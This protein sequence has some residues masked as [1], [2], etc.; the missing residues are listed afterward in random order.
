VLR[1]FAFL[2]VFLAHSF[3]GTGHLVKSFQEA[4][5][6]GL[7]LFF[8]LSSFL[9]TELLRRERAKTGTIDIKRFY[10]RRILRIW[11]LYLSFVIAVFFLWHGAQPPMEPISQGR[12]LSYMGLSANWYAVL[13]RNIGLSPISPLWSIS[14]EE[15]FYLLWP[16]MFLLGGKRLTTLLSLATLPVAMLSIYWVTRQANASDVQLWP[17]SFV[18]FIFFGLGALTALYSEHLPKLNS[19]LSRVALLLVSL[20]VSLAG[21]YLFNPA[22]PLSM[23]MS[24]GRYG[25][26]LAATAGIFLAFYG[27]TWAGSFSFPV[28]LGKISYGLYVFHMLSIEAAQIC[29]PILIRYVKH[30]GTVLQLALSLTFTI[31]LAS[32][33]YR[34]LETPFLRLKDK[35]TIIASRSV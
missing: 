34:Y 14:V 7:P 22:L 24:L 21:I 31:A 19:A 2:S 17:N 29:T 9:I 1:L 25:C 4:L 13:T 10:V 8:F 15:Q 5:H 18:V 23:G 3:F 12:F 28:Y 20:L 6:V 35:F 33:S 32:L 11:P 16:M 26:M 27:W 30:G